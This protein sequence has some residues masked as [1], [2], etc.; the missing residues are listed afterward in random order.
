MSALTKLLLPRWGLVAPASL[1][2]QSGLHLSF[3][4]KDVCNKKHTMNGSINAVPDSSLAPLE[5]RR[6]KWAWLKL[7]VATCA[8]AATFILMSFVDTLPQ[9]LRAVSGSLGALLA[10]VFFALL[11]NVAK[12]HPACIVR[13]D[14]ILIPRLL[15]PFNRCLIPWADLLNVTLVDL[16]P[17]GAPLGRTGIFG[18]PAIR[19]TLSQRFFL[20]RSVVVLIGESDHSPSEIY[21]NI[22]ARMAHALDRQ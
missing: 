6:S 8:V 4:S 14:G 16:A 13:D 12:G 21:S 3:V 10:L 7:L 11:G 9:G 20:S 5:V 1:R 18:E 22:R 17:A 19:L 2:L 15:L